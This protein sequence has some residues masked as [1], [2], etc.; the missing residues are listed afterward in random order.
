VGFDM[1]KRK[2]AGLSPMPSYSEIVESLYGRY[3]SFVEGITVK[4]VIY[5]K[6]RA[7]RFII[8]KSD[9]GFYKYL[10]EEICVCD[11]DEWEM[12]SAI[13]GAEPACWAPKNTIGASFF[14]NERDAE[15]AIT[16]E[17]EYSDYFI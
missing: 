1:K 5:S 9:K 16:F 15:I 11:A 10:Y 8:I 6:D 12:I 17:P 7:K 4:R 3:P 13:E 14:E 2:K